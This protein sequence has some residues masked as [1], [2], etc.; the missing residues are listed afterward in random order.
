M[1]GLDTRNHFDA[2]ERQCRT[3]GGWLLLD[4]A[5]AWC[6]QKSVA[7]PMQPLV[8]RAFFGRDLHAE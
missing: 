2:A 4:A 8:L 7:D 6:R 5:C 1:S 3:E